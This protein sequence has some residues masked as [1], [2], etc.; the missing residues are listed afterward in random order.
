MRGLLCGSL[1]FWRFTVNSPR[2][3]SGPKTKTFLPRSLL[4]SPAAPFPNQQH[5]RSKTVRTCWKLFSEYCFSPSTPGNAIK[6][7]SEVHLRFG[8]T[9]QKRTGGRR[10]MGKPS[11]YRVTQLGLFL[12]FRFGRGSLHTNSHQVALLFSKSASGMWKGVCVWC[13]W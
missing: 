9:S 1:L 2:L 4:L 6:H 11:K 10:G 5:P 12:L 3:G 7:F 8:S 13:A